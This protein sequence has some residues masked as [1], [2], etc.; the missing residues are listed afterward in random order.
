MVFPSIYL[1]TSRNLWAGTA[2]FSAV[3]AMQPKMASGCAL[4]THQHDPEK[5]HRFSEKIMPE[6][7]H[8]AGRHS[9]KVIPPWAGELAMRLTGQKPAQ[10]TGPSSP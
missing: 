4:S 6:Q 5:C 7:K 3:L 2:L 1:F 8:R 9:K 10:I